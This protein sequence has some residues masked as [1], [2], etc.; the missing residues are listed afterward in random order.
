[1]PSID[2]KIAQ[3]AVAAA[4]D[5]VSFPIVLNALRDLDHPPPGADDT[6]R[7]LHFVGLMLDRGF[8][9]VTSPYDTPPGTPW[10]E[11]GRDAVLERL[12][13]EWDALD[14]EPT[15][16]DLCWFHRPRG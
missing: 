12:R 8:V 13:R 11:R 4:T 3:L 6:E 2:E 1:M 9:P 14:H 10:P 15:F 16:L 7:L 5:D